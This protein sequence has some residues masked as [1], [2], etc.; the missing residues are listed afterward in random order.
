MAFTSSRAYRIV[1]IGRR[2]IPQRQ[3]L[4]LNLS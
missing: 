1:G 3:I 4:I 2:E